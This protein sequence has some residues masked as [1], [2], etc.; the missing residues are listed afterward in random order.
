MLLLPT[1]GKPPVPADMPHRWNWQAPGKTGVH[2]A[3]EGYR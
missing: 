1:P 2:R 3:R